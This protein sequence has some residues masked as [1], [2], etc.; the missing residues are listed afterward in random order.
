[1]IKIWG[2]CSKVTEEIDFLGVKTSGHVGCA[3]TL[4]CLVVD[5]Y[6]LSNSADKQTLKGVVVEETM[7]TVNSFIV[8]LRGDILAVCSWGDRMI[9][10]LLASWWV[11]T[12]TVDE[13]GVWDVIEDEIER[14][15][16]TL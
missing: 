7:L 1:M 16:E 13:L 3:A 6:D 2:C 5:V 12:L 15:V 9:H 10:K 14:N 11:V 4:H 8:H